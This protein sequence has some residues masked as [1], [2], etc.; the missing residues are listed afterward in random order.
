[1]REH[2]IDLDCEIDAHLHHL[3]INL[4]VKSS[5]VGVM[6]SAVAPL[7]VMVDVLALCVL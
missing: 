4:Q 7:M 6:K 3:Y 1:M 2:L 5:T